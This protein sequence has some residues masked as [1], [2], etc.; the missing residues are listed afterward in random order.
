MKCE[1]RINHRTTELCPRSAN[2][3]WHAIARDYRICAECAAD[4]YKDP[5][6][7]ESLPNTAASDCPESSAPDALQRLDSVY[8]PV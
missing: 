5:A 6:D 3:L 8:R 1:M 7:I 2:F 4:P